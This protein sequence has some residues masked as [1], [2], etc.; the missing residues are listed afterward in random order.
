[1][2]RPRLF[3]AIKI[4]LSPEFLN[5]YYKLK[6]GLIDEKIKWVEEEN[7]HITLK[8][9]G[10]TP[11]DKIPEIITELKE[12]SINS[13]P[14]QLHLGNT[15]I[16]GSSYKPKVVWFGISP[17]DELQQLHTN[18]RNQLLNIGYEQGSENFV[19]HLT[20]GRIKYIQD[21]KIFQLIINEYK[22]TSIQTV[23]VKAFYLLES[24]LRKEGPVYRVVE[25][26]NL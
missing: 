4:H 3:A 6:S 17:C 15:G 5:I 23:E 12:A 8:F 2:N 10:E 11:E 25:T 24:I 7:F 22:K 14:F 16:F 18:I 20:V 9:F 21:K 26:L 13:Q 19:P 1:M